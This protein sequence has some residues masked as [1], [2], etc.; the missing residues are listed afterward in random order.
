ME[1]ILNTYCPL[2]LIFIF[3]FQMKSVTLRYIV[4]LLL[5]V[6]N[7]HSPKSHFEYQI[8]GVNSM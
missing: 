2:F 7:T 1:D 6:K 4:H 3:Q 8:V 5:A